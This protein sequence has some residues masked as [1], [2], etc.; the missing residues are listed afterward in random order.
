MGGRLIMSLI[1]I[2]EFIKS[3]KFPLVKNRHDVYML[4]RMG[5]LKTVK[6][7]KRRYIVDGNDSEMKNDIS[8]EKRKRKINIVVPDMIYKLIAVVADREKKDV[9]EF[10]EDTMEKIK[11]IL[12]YIENSSGTK[13]IEISC[14]S[15][16]KAKKLFKK[17]NFSRD[18]RLNSRERIR[19]NKHLNVLVLLITLY[20]SMKFEYNKN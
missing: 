14:D 19:I 15:S 5:G 9:S 17:I 10:I 11:T 1:T 18:K 12:S 3:G 4:I 16:E 7:G 20:A 8:K 6:I 2:D 13:T